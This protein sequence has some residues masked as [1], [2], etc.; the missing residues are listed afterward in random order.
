MR[1]WW[2]ALLLVGCRTTMEPRFSPGVARSFA[3]EPVRKLTTPTLE[4]YYPASE[5]SAALRMAASLDACD[6]ALRTRAHLAPR[7]RRILAYLTGAPFDNA[8]V[9]G[10]EQGEPLH[11]VIPPVLLNEEFAYAN[12]LPLHDT[13]HVACHE[14]VHVLQAEQQGPL[15]R[16]V[17]GL[18]GN[19][20]DPQ[21]FLERWFAEGLAQFYEGRLRDG[22]GRTHNAF[23]RGVWEASVAAHR[24]HIDFTELSVLNRELW[25]ITGAYLGSL[26]FVEYLAGRFGEDALWSIVRDQ[27]DAVY[28]LLG[29]NNTFRGTLEVS[30]SRLL[31]DWAAT[32]SARPARERPLTQQVLA[33]NVGPW[34]RLSSSPDGW[35]AVVHA[36][37]DEASTLTVYDP[38]G[39]VRWSLPLEP[40]W[41]ERAFER[42]RPQDI[43]GLSISRGGRRVAFMTSDLAETGEHRTALVV[44]DP[45]S[46]RV[47]HHVTDLKGIGGDLRADG[48]RYVWA[49]LRSGQTRLAE[50]DLRSAEVVPL[51]PWQERTLLDPRYAPDGAQLAYAAWTGRGYDAFVRDP[52]GHERQLT[53]SGGYQHQLRWLDAASIVLVAEVEAHPQLLTFDLTRGRVSVLTDAPHAVLD[54]AP[55]PGARVAFLNREDNHFSIDVVSAITGAEAVEVAR[56]SPAVPSLAATQVESEAEASSVEGLAWPQLHSPRIALAPVWTLDG[57]AL[58]QLYGLGFVGRDRLARHT[59]TF[60]A[61]LALPH[62]TTL[63]SAGYLNQAL[64]PVAFDTLFSW[65]H[66]PGSDGFLL[67]SLIESVAFGAHLYGGMDLRMSRYDVGSVSAHLGLTAGF[68]FAATSESSFGV[69]RGVEAWG[70]FSAWPRTPLNLTGLADAALG[71]RV[72]LPVPWVTRAEFSLEGRLRAV[73]G[74]PSPALVLGG[75]ERGIVLSRFNGR[76]DDSERPRITL[77][78]VFAEP[79]RGFEDASVVAT[80]AAIGA[81]RLSYPFVI[82]RGFSSLFYVL[83]SF[84]IQQIDLDLFGS[85]AASDRA[86]TPV[87][88]ASGAA[89][90]FRSALMEVVRLSLGYEFAGRFADRPSVLHTILLTVQ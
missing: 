80:R 69:R 20:I 51:S 67:S 22:T 75:L 28:G 36:Q 44:V 60:D 85:V 33:P 61:E 76:P 41:P 14:M 39:T 63:L 49:E 78:Q 23:Y 48:E 68:S 66:Q 1:F 18:L 62:A 59:W 42:A 16:G 17:N 34:A 40:I 26:P 38:A 27:G 6:A 7:S 86:L 56:E 5:R 31:K 12:T 89:I 54:P 10:F 79:L 21:A 47:L 65:G 81:A 19:V 55:L 84:F 74:P 46:G 87:L 13:G 8:Y 15:F 64:A 72:Y 37:I 3:V 73:V 45:A 24:G 70:Q 88:G 9:T 11:L 32:L 53:F 30:L 52:D 71:A 4:L 50:I 58:G 2:V 43:S 90:T 29:A 77:P 83:P 57:F 82:D 35:L 25:P